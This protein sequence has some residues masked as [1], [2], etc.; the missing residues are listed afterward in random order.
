LISISTLSSLLKTNP[1]S[2]GVCEGVGKEVS[3]GCSV[4]VGYGAVVGIAISVGGGCVIAVKDNDIMTD[5][6]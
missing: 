6:P 2:V 4:A 3:V 5:N 1:G